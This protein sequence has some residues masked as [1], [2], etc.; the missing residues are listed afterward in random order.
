MPDYFN[1]WNLWRFAGPPHQEQKLEPTEYKRFLKRGGLLVRNTY[2]FDCQEETGFWNLIKDQFEGLEELSSNTRN[3]VLKSQENLDFRLIDFSLVES[4]GYPILKAT[5]DDYAT[6]DRPM[7]RK[8]FND[9]LQHCKSKDYDY[10]G[11]FDKKN[12]QF[13]GFCANHVWNEAAE[14]GTIGIL[15]E[16]K[17][18]GT[19]PYYGLFYTMNKYYLQEKG[20]RYITDGTRSITE[21]SNIQDFL[22]EKFNFRKSYCR[23]VIYYRLWLKLAVKM[24]YPFRKSLS[25]PRVKAIL[26]MEAMQRGEK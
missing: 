11:I 17:H 20:F 26:N 16:Y 5:F 24:L 2:D 19:F 14:Y 9:Y 10:W 8:I 21:H 3:R 22:I 12:D 13:I 7:N 6:T 4:E 23:L 15:P 25:L 1:H 18:N